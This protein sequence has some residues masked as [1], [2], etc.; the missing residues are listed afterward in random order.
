MGEEENIEPL[1]NEF[2]SENLSA[3]HHLDASLLYSVSEKNKNWNGVFGISL[4]NIYNQRNSYQ[5][6]LFIEDPPNKPPELT[7][8]DKVDVGFMPNF[9]VRI[10][11]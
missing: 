1:I 2:N 3:I 7:Y 5:R 10:K 9:V 4:Y 11:F 6:G 8:S